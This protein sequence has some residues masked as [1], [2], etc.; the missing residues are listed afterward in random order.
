MVIILSKFALL[1]KNGSFEN[2]NTA[3]LI[4]SGAVAN[5]HEVLMFFMHDAVW[6]LKKD[7]Y[8]TTRNIHSVYPEVTAQIQQVDKDGKLQVWF[9]LIPQLKEIGEIKIV[10]CGL[11][12]DVFGLKKEDLVDFV[13]EVA[14]VA[15]FTGEADSSENIM[16]IG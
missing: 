8:L 4:A 3:A 11:M 14:G 16:V 9:N 2:L 5:D 12:M 13:D 1:V 10:A 6:S 7:V 15:Y